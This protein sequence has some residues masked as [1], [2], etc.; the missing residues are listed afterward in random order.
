MLI[1]AIFFISIV[2][3]SWQKAHAAAQLENNSVKWHPGHYYQIL[4]WGKNN[5]THLEQVYREIQETPALRGVQIRYS[6]A[7][8]EKEWGVYDF[9]SIDQ[10]LA[11]LA[12]QKKRLIILLDLK[13]YNTSI[14]PAP[15]YTN[16]K[17]FDWGVFAFSR[18]NSTI[19]RGYNISLWNSLVHDRLAALISRMGKRYNSHPYFEG[20]GLTE[21]SMGTPINA[22]S[23]AQVDE[24]YNNMLS[25]HQH[26]REH[27]PNTMTYQNTNYPRQILEQFTNR[28]AELGTA[29]AVPDVFIEDPGLNLKDK[30]YTPDGVYSYFQKLS[31]IVPLAPSVMHLDYTNTRHDGTGYDPTVQ[32]LL[33]YARDNLNAN[34]IFWMR[35]PEHYEEVLQVLNWRNQTSDPAG[36]L[37]STCPATYFSCVDIVESH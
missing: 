18:P 26:M 16:K 34:Y 4:D 30:L 23:S 3:V 37:D 32:E 33:S 29:L 31:G 36:G 19:P 24:Y 8:L 10:R 7:E 12:A 20:I 27:F 15:D 1:M 2:L 25:L 22:L 6:W 35:I 17:W 21:T 11:E 28:L 5:P 13:T 14:S 9:T